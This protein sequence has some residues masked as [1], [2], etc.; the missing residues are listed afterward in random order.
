MNAHVLVM[1]KD[2]QAFVRLVSFGA[3][4]SVLI[5][6]AHLQSISVQAPFSSAAVIVLFLFWRKVPEWNSAIRVDNSKHV[7]AAWISQAL[8]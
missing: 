6:K 5:T 1:K 7:S 3:V 8:K 4:M 2:I